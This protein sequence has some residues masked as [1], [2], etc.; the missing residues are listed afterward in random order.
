[1]KSALADF[2][3]GPRMTRFGS[4]LDKVLNGLA[5]LAGCLMMIALLMVC[6]DVVMRYFFNSP[7][8]G[9]LQF[10]EYVLLYI[11][12]LAAAYVLKDDSH[13]KIDIV[14]NRLSPKLQ[15]TLNMVT[16]MFGFLVLLVLTYYGTYITLDY[17]RRGVPTLKYYKIP[18][19]LVIMVIPLG[20]FLFALQFIRKACGY[21][22]AIKDS[23]S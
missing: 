22:R 6:I 14:L 8:G 1:M 21:Y 18:E 15:A 17:Y 2:M 20:C 19:F 7:I 11:P 12:F 9:V 4:F 23:G 3:N 5:C 10:S 16:S 13:I